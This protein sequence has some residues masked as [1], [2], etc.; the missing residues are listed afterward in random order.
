MAV[1][2]EDVINHI[3]LPPDPAEWDN[4]T[5]YINGSAV[6]HN[7]YIWCSTADDNITEPGTANAKW[8]AIGQTAACR[9][10][11]HLAA[12]KS[13]ARTAGIPAFKNNAQ[14]DSFIKDLAAMYYD[15]R[16]M[17]FGGSYQATAEENARKMINGHGAYRR[18]WHRLLFQEQG[19]SK[20]LIAIR[21]GKNTTLQLE[22]N[23]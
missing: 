6:S 13:K 8:I 16:G 18:E 14:Y 10:A 1:T 19:C 5:A 21:Q 9:V 20:A 17:A 3:G 12:A 22:K 7:D 4:S 11:P 15:N 2:V 23:Y